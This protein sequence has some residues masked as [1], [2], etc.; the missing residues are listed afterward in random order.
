MNVSGI[1]L[2]P[3]PD[4]GV[5]FVF[6]FKF[7]FSGLFVW[8]FFFS[9]SSFLSFLVISS[10]DVLAL[11]KVIHTLWSICLPSWRRD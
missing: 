9:S 3:K 2:K 7:Y 10:A 8:F 1:V 4:T 11:D 5:V 6:V